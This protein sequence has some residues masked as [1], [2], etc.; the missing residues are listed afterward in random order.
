M[1]LYHNSWMHMIYL[2]E[3]KTSK[4][5]IRNNG[6]HMVRIIMVC[7]VRKIVGIS[8]I[9]ALQFSCSRTP[10]SAHKVHAHH[11]TNQQ[12][13]GSMS[14]AHHNQKHKSGIHDT[15]FKFY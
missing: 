2:K 3:Y 15:K 4:K 8:L 13:D 7:M 12:K 14:Q 1:L 6:M 11:L 5:D 9:F 10:I